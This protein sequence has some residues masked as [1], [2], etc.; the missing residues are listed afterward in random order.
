MKTWIFS[1]EKVTSLEVEGEYEDNGMQQVWKSH[2]WSRYA[3]EV[4]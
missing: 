1:M 3:A 4:S 2:A